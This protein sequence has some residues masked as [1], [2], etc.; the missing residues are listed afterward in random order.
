MRRWRKQ[1]GSVK[2]YKIDAACA[3]GSTVIESV[4]A[5]IA[6]NGLSEAVIAALTVNGQC[7]DLTVG[8]GVPG[9]SYVVKIDVTSF[10]T[11]VAEYARALYIDRVFAAW[12]IG[13]PAGT[14]FGPAVTWQSN[15]TQLNFSKAR[16][17]WLAAGL[18]S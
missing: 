12:P 1:P 6:P 16:N 4:S 7:V 9:R 15:A 18:C 13:D 10:G 2:T 5:A 11:P 14:A 17:S 8:G 3:L